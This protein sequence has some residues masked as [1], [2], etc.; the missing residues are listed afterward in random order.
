[1]PT[2][3]GVAPT[4]AAQLGATWGPFADVFNATGQPS[5][6]LPCGFDRDGLPIGLMLSGRRS[7]DDL[8]LRVARAYESAT[9]WHA[10]RPPIAA[11]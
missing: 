4:L 7:E 9:P 11:A 1:M 6:T 5:I 3:T 2:K 10:R 8:V